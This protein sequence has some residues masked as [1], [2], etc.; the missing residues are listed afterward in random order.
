MEPEDLLPFSYGPATGPHPKPGECNPHYS[1][2]F[3]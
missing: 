3:P 2:L 1:T